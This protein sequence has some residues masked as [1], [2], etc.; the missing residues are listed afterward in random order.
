MYSKQFTETHDVL[1]TISS[2]AANA[3]V[4]EHH[5]GQ[6]DLADYHRA[7]IWLDLGEADPGA[8]I[9]IFVTQLGEGDVWEDDVW[10]VQETHVEVGGDPIKGSKLLVGKALNNLVEADQGGHV[11]M[12]LRSEELDANSGYHAI[13]VTVRVSVSSYR[14]SMLVLGLVSRLTPVGVTDFLQLVQ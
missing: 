6:V 14:Y 13:Q 10:T 1:A 5:T 2:L 7:F 9:D 12:E 3:A 4:G 8:S 11:G